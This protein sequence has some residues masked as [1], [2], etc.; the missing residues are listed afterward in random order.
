MSLEKV[1]ESQIQDAI[2]AGAFDNLPGGGKPQEWSE[3]EKLAGDNWLGYKVLQ[4]GG[5]VPPWLGL[6]REV[7]L[8]LEKLAALDRQHESL[9]RLAAQDRAWTRYAGALRNL[10]DK[11]EALARAIRR[12]QD[13]Y[14]LQAPGIRSERPGIWV[15]CHLERLHDRVHTAG[16]PTG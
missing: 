7:E 15:E 6:A 13:T 11:Y 3:A 9:C 14:N 16:G 12:K 10:F 5:M 4:N 8:D 1:I 2:A